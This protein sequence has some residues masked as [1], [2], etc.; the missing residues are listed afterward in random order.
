MTTTLAFG[1]VGLGWIFGYGCGWAM[2]EAPV[3]WSVAALSLVMTLS[4]LA[5]IVG[6]P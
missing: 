4:L 2:R 5:F 6:S 3:R 1:Y